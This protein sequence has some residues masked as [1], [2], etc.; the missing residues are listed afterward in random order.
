MTQIN[1]NYRLGDTES[2]QFGFRHS[3]DGHFQLYFKAKDGVEIAVPLPVEVRASFRAALVDIA[4]EGGDSCMEMP[5]TI[6]VPAE[7]CKNLI[8]EF[9]QATR[10]H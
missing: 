9:D 5:L 2:F 10:V 3:D 4:E 7:I 6:R 1:S 8:E